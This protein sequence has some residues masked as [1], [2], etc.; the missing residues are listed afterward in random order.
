MH[1][2]VR[3]SEVTCIFQFLVV[4]RGTG[5]TTVGLLEARK[6]FV[7]GIPR[8]LD[9]TAQEGV[10]LTWLVPLLPLSSSSSA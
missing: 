6:R 7:R 5:R 10:A 3:V 9:A 4:R 1:E 8:T 2:H